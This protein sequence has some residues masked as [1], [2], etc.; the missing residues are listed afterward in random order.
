MILYGRASSW[1]GTISYASVSLFTLLLSPATGFSQEYREYHCTPDTQYECI[2]GR[3]E[4][5][6]DGFQNA[7]SFIYNTKNGELSA[8]LWTNCYVATATTVKDAADGVLIAIGKLKPVVHSGNEL[9][10][11]SLTISNGN[12]DIAGEKA[13]HFTAVWGYGGKG[14]TLD[15]GKCEFRK[16]S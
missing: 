16:F 5:I 10:I 13:S 11:V 12:S 9:I 2:S 14:L 15:T 1:R 7:E 6:N 8:C 4:K 3:C